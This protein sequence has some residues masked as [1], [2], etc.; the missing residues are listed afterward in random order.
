MNRLG[1]GLSLTCGAVWI[2]ERFLA[3]AVLG[4]QASLLPFNF[5]RLIGEVI[6]YFGLVGLVEELLFRGLVYRL[7]DSWRGPG[8][9]IFG[10]AF[11]FA[12]W[13]IGWAGPL[14]VGHF[15]VGIVFGMIRWRAGGIVGLIIVHGLFDIVSVEIPI[16]VQTYDQI[17]HANINPVAAVIGDILLIVL[18]LY[19]WKIH[20]LVERR[21]KIP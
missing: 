9:A 3:P 21:F 19:L 4:V 15:L 20:P 8:L 11:G 1:I 17:L 14:M 10:S 2:A 12:I 5:W 16:S 7:L 13:H 6:F 18:V